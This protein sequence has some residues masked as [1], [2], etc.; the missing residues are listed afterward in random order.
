MVRE[1]TDDQA[2]ILMLVENLQ[3][4]DLTPREEAA[5]LEVLL[6]Q[7]GWT[8]RQVGEA[9]KRSH[10]YVS[11][12]LRVFEDEALAPLVLR[13]QSPLPVSTAEELLGIHDLDRRRALAEQAANEQWERPRVRKAVREAAAALVRSVPSARE[14]GRKVVRLAVELQQLLSDPAASELPAPARSELRRLYQRLVL[15]AAD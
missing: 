9:I 7:R 11:R 13:E 6:R 3:R 14:H 10:A 12:R 15:L 5:A 8:T 4:E 2:Y 1:E